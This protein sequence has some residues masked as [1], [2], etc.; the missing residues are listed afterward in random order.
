MEATTPHRKKLTVPEIA[1]MLGVNQSKVLAWIAADELRALNVASTRA[2][3][4]RW[5]IDP[6]DLAAFEASRANTSNTTT[7]ATRSTRSRRYR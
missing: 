5:R 7:P 6:G 2:T 3:R 4:P 1:R